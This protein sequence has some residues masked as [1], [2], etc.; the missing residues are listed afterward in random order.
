MVAGS[1]NVHNVFVLRVVSVGHRLARPLH[2]AINLADAN[3]TIAT[4]ARAPEEG[5]LSAAIETAGM[6]IKVFHPRRGHCQD[7]F[8]RLG[9][10]AEGI[11]LHRLD[12][13]GAIATVK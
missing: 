2:T 12:G 5:K 3:T 13:G 9:L 8:S 1:A 11:C 4:M 7:G 10:G 6:V